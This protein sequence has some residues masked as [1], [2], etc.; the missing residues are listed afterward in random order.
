MS[1]YDCFHVW[2]AVVTDFN[3]VL[4]EDFMELMVSG[5]VSLD[6]FEEKAADV[7]GDVVVK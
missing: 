3:I 7:G 2:H 5:E 4:F 6:Q 1:V